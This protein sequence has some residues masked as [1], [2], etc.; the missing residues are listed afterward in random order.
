MK[1][2]FTLVLKGHIAVSTAR[3]PKGT[4]GVAL[5]GFARRALWAEGLNFDHGTGHGVGVYLGVHEGPARLSP[6][7]TVPLEVGMILS[8]EPGYYETGSHGIRIENLVLV[9]E[10]EKPGFLSFE[11]L[12]FCPIDRRAIDVSLL[13]PEERSWLNHYHAQVRDKLTP[14]VSGRA[15]SWLLK[16]TKPL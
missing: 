11:T 4:T 15:L 6:M 2:H 10:D 9:R 14:L 8:N 7:G 3:F 5:D 16:M 13:S 12:T 1:K